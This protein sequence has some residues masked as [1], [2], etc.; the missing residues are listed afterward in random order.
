[1]E[2]RRILAVLETRASNKPAA[3]RCLGI[4]RKRMEGK[5]AGCRIAAADGKAEPEF[6]TMAARARPRR[7]AYQSFHQGSFLSSPRS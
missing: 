5:C 2:K 1:M 4:A 3:A 7:P 6:P